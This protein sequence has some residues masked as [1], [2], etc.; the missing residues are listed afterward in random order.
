MPVGGEDKHKDFS[1][2]NLIDHPVFLGDFSAPSALRLALQRLGMP[3]TRLGM[4]LQFL[5]EALGLGEG[6]GLFLARRTRSASAMSR[7]ICAFN[8]IAVIILTHLI[9]GAKIRISKQ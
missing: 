5:D 7:H 3:Q 1:L 6:F 2:E 8:S 9:S 4:H